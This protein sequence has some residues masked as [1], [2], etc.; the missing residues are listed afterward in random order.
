NVV[1]LLVSK[2]HSIVAIIAFQVLEELPSCLLVFRHGL[3]VAC[4]KPVVSRVTT[5]DRT[6]ERRDRLEDVVYRGITLENTLKLLVVPRN[7][8]NLGDNFIFLSLG[9]HIAAAPCCRTLSF[10]RRAAAVPIKFLLIADIP[11]SG[12]APLQSFLSHPN[13]F[14]FTVG[15]SMFANVAGI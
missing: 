14:R 7:R 5:N 9:S 10:E 12:A 6:L 3:L 8:I 1:V 15:Q 2:Q 11:Q 4:F 13:R